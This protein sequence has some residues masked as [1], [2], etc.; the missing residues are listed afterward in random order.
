MPNGLRCAVGLRGGGRGT[1]RKNV[2]RF[3][4]LLSVAVRGAWLIAQTDEGPPGCPSGPSKPVRSILP[5][6]WTARKSPGRHSADALLSPGGSMERSKTRAGQ[7]MR[8]PGEG[9][10]APASWADYGGGRT[11][12]EAAPWRILWSDD[13]D[14]VAGSNQPVRAGREPKTDAGVGCSAP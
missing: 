14:A 5:N 13:A 6:A 11:S 2:A 3:R 8:A 7:A 4:Q 9:G 10:Y 1:A 12:C